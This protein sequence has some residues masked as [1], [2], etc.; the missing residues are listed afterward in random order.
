[1][2]KDCPRD[3]VVLAFVQRHLD[4]A[5]ARDVEAHIDAC[6][7]CRELVSAL[8]VAS[9][10]SVTRPG[11]PDDRARAIHPGVQ[12]GRFEVI[13]VGGKNP[14]VLHSPE[15]VPL[16]GSA[17]NPKKLHS[18]QNGPLK[19]RRRPTVCKTFGEKVFLFY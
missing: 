5:E 1:M 19:I 14:K 7:A 6:A 13:D 15:K 11:V 3:D 16:T 12:V 2:T 4:D 18:V 9:T 10:S 17:K 8:A